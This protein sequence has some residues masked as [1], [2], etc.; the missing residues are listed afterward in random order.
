MK[1]NYL[2]LLFFSVIIGC[3]S[4][5]LPE[6]NSEFAASPFLMLKSDQS[7]VRDFKAKLDINSTGHATYHIRKVTTVLS[8]DA[9]E[10]GKLILP[11]GGF[12]DIL[13][14]EGALYS[15]N[16]DLIRRLDKSD[17]LDLSLS[18]G[19][20]LYEDTRIK[21][22]ELYF[23][24]YPY[25]IVYDYEIE[26]TGLLNLPTFYPQSRNQYV[27]KASLEVRTPKDLRLKY[28]TLNTGSSVK[29]R[30]VDQDSVFRWEMNELKPLE[31][32][33]FGKSF[34]EVA[35]RI[36]LATES[37]KIAD[38]R[39]KLDSWNS[40]G[41]WYYRLAKDRNDLPESVKTEINTIFNNAD[42]REQ[43]IRE[44]YKY[45]Q[46]KTRYVSVQLGIGGWQPFEAKYVEE[47][48]Y[49]DCKALTNY[50][51]AILNY[52]GVE[53]YPVLIKNGTSEP[54]IVTDFP[55]NQFNH[56]ILWVPEAD[57]IWLE[58]TSQT[59]P[60]NYI[61]FSN[62]DRHGL[63]V[64]PDSSFLLKAPTYDYRTNKLRN[65][66]EF[67]LDRKGNVV[68]DIRSSYSGYYLDELL[69]N[70]AKKSESGRQEWIHE[71]FTLNSF[72]IEHSDFTDI[73]N[74]KIEPV[75]HF[76]ISN[77]RY[78][79]QTGTRLFVPINKLNKWEQEFPAMDKERSE[80]IHLPYSFREE[81]TSVIKLPAG[82]NVEAIPKSVEIST[83][84]STY[85]L[86]IKNEDNQV[87]IR[88]VLEVKKRKL[89]PAKYEELRGFFA[90]V[91]TNDKKNIVLK[92]R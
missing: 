91:N 49:G 90:S 80:E 92:A 45:M 66:A 59:I 29:K 84:F 5:R 4:H 85:S 34:V 43:G 82:F 61:G 37:F 13:G 23:N 39:G 67:T 51:Q 17:G 11:Y 72:E 40:F 10:S 56:V 86:E 88:R 70:I 35:P 19:Y 64:T 28:R 65:D 54:D 27:E 32:E 12:Q 78:A 81:D 6:S 62:S 1:C 48:G 46:N 63:V 20:T 79:T 74:R 2:I 18:G 38:S 42:D 69:G 30:F 15:A 71:Q 3:S 36:L 50:M 8:P 52:A 16:G 44:L 75:L 24:E 7:V 53:S 89:P 25:T 9:R 87:E 73:D 76:K 33:P 22:Y 21:I 58:S 60:F 83:D 31:K 57:T 47:K 55:S 77:P 41:Q 68:I 14:V 26:L